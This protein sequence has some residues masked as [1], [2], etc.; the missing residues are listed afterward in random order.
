MKVPAPQAA[1]NV[2]IKCIRMRLMAVY[3]AACQSICNAFLVSLVEYNF[4]NILVVKQ[5]KGNDLSSWKS[6][7]IQNDTVLQLYR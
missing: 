6:V 4:A 5:I 7:F 1:G 2:P 3:T